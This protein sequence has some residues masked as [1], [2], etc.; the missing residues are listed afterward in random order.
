M[1]H[2]VKIM[3]RKEKNITTLNQYFVQKDVLTPEEKERIK[4]RERVAKILTSDYY[5]NKNAN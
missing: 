4:E 2:D 5:T 1:K 3:S